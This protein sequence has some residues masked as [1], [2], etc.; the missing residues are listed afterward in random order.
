MLTD[1]QKICKEQ[2][3]EEHEAKRRILIKKEQLLNVK[4]QLLREKLNRDSV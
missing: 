4:M 2:L 1:I 3:K